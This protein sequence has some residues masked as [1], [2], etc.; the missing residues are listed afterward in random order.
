MRVLLLQNFLLYTQYIFYDK[1]KSPEIY[2]KYF[3]NI[4]KIFS[5][6]SYNNTQNKE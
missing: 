3:Q 1:Y 5:N 6:S 4:D 2:I